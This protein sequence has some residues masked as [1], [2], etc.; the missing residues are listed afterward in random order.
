MDKNKEY[1][2]SMRVRMTLSAHWQNKLL[3]LM[4][5]H[6]SISESYPQDHTIYMQPDAFMKLMCAAEKKGICPTF[7]Q[8]KVAYVDLKQEPQITVVRLPMN[9]SKI[10]KGDIE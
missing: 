7:Q 2:P 4:H 10:D 8:I 9:Y 3:D 6:I 1:R 5:E